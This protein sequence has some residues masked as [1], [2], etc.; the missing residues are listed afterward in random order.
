MS[1]AK[2]PENF[3]RP[4]G[5]PPMPIGTP[6]QRPLTPDELKQFDTLL[7]HGGGP[8]LIRPGDA[9]TDDVHSQ[10]RLLQTLIVAIILLAI[11]AGAMYLFR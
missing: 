2:S 3:D 7:G 6:E 11:V 5:P 1:V 8:T 10:S 4:A 9:T